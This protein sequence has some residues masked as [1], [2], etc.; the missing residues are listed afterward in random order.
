MAANPRVDLRRLPE[1]MGHADKTTTQRY[2][3][4]TPRHDDAELVAEGVRDECRRRTVCCA[5]HCLSSS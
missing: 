4:F 1:W 5:I 2:S 3:H